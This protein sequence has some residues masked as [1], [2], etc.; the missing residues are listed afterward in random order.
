MKS[1]HLPNVAFRAVGLTLLALVANPLS[2]QQVVLGP[3]HMQST[4]TSVV[5][6]WRTDVPT[7]SA[8]KFG[9]DAAALDKEAKTKWKTTEH[10]MI[11]EGLTPSTKYHYAVG[12]AEKSLAT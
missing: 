3:Y 2:A 6:L 4:P 10:V 11:L 8:V 9:L 5:L 12:N 1:L 7:D